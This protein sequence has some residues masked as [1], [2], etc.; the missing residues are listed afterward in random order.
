MIKKTFTVIAGLLII[1]GLTAL[2]L[3]GA[4]VA[5]YLQY[6]NHWTV[7]ATEQKFLESDRK[8]SNPNCGFYNI[9]GFTIKD[10]EDSYAR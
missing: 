9:Y 8:L 10:T 6:R 4:F 1:L 5:S 7:V 3:S 2:F